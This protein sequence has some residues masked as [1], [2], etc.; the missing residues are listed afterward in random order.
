MNIGLRM[1][2]LNLGDLGWDIFDHMA[3]GGEKI[4]EHQHFTGTTLYTGLKP[5]EIEG[6]ASSRKAVATSSTGSSGMERIF[7]AS[8]R[9]SSFEDSRRL[10]WATINKIFIMMLYS[11]L[12]L[13][14]LMVTQH[15]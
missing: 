13:P 12:C 5:S 11:N 15:P 4:R 2:I 6:S 9:T 14:A 1:F 8:C 3:A 7:S 10:P